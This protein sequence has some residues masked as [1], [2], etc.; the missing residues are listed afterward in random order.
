MQNKQNHFVLFSHIP[1]LNLHTLS[2]LRSTPSSPKKGKWDKHCY[3]APRS[4][5]HFTGFVESQDLVQPKFQQ[6]Q[7]THWAIPR[8][9]LKLTWVKASHRWQEVGPEETGRSLSQER[10]GRKEGLGRSPCFFVSCEVLCPIS[11]YRRKEPWV[12]ARSPQ[13]ILF[14]VTKNCQ[15]PALPSANTLR[16]YYCHQESQANFL[17]I[18][19]TAPATKKYNTGIC[20]WEV[21]VHLRHIPIR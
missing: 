2:A 1:F 20:V 13:K 6:G 4:Q 19:E 15:S 16:T 5:F 3:P 18:K 12:I 7:S 11:N 9:D 21:L 10:M 17:Q 14:W 8:P